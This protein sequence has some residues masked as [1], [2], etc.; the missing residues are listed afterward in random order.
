MNLLFYLHRFPGYGG[1]E[2]VTELIGNYLICKGH[3]VALMVTESQERQSLLI[4]NAT[5]FKLPDS[6]DLCSEENRVCADKIIKDASFDAIIFQNSYAPNDKLICELANKYEIPLYIFEHNT[7]LYLTK[8]Y[9]LK[10]WWHP[11]DVYRYLR[12]S[13]KVFRNNAVLR[14]C[15]VN[16][17]TKYVLL[18]Q[19]FIPE[20]VK[21]VGL[22][23][24]ESKKL[25]AINNPIIYKPISKSLMVKKENIVLCVGRIEDQKRIDLMVKMWE[26]MKH[27]DWKFVIVGD[28]SQKENL[29]RYADEHHI[30]NIEWVPYCD[31]TP[32]YERAKIFWMTS[33]FEGWGLTLVEAMQKGCVP[34]VYHSYSSLPDIINDGEDGYIVK[35]LHSREF[36]RRTRQLMFD[37]DLYLRMAINA[38]NSAGR[39]DIN[40]IG[41]QWERLF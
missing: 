25:T 37:E 23:K 38:V 3:H 31:P 12:F 29:M 27:K 40:I 10:R 35:D 21:Y 33:L 1:I 22:N 26:K 36:I 13:K 14:R 24:E 9:R 7:P 18:S 5:Y 17:C 32:Y 34:V 11:L 2:T 15:H 28:G 6:K 16:C 19:Y 41:Q 8:I 30:P 4:Q 20:F 39:F